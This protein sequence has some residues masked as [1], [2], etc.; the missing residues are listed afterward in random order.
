MKSSI[1]FDK[2]SYN[3]D[4]LEVNG[5]HSNWDV[6]LN[7][8]HIKF[9]EFKNPRLLIFD[10]YDSHIHDIDI[11]TE[12]HIEKHSE[13]DLLSNVNLKIRI[14]NDKINDARNEIEN[15][16]FFEIDSIVD[17][18]RGVYKFDLNQPIK[19]TSGSTKIRDYLNLVRSKSIEEIKK[20]REENLERYETNKQKYNYN[21]NI[22][23]TSE[24]VEEIR[25]EL[26]KKGFCFLLK[27]KNIF[28]EN[29]S[30]PYEFVTIIT[31][32]YLDV[33]EFH[34]LIR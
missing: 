14:N 4:K 7:D 31:D 1:I 34:E 20:V 8:I 15:L 24:K 28:G 23:M 29:V 17:P 6:F 3:K 32:F 25:R 12:K 16:K 13:D 2:S 27:F 22:E 33:F 10:Y 26:F 11:Y 30:T 18:Y 9:Y 5:F 19:V 21:R